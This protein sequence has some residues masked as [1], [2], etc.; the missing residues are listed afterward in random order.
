MNIRKIVCFFFVAAAF[1][2]VS[3][4]PLSAQTPGTPSDPLVT[5][6][7]LD[8]MFRFRPLPLV[9]GRSLELPQGALF[10]LR[11]GKAKIHGP[12]GAVLIDLTAGSELGDGAAI[13]AN[14]LILVPESAPGLK[15]TTVAPS[16]LY[17]SGINVEN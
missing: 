10:V 6:S 12:K 16:R 2:L 3:A 14:H 17:V 1:L 5:K 7:Y 8:F 15:I 4:H 11:S 9:A 13:P